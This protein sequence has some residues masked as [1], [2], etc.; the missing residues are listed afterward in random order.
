MIS[1]TFINPSLA[2]AVDDGENSL[3]T[4]Q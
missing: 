3:Q 2:S 1:E 4:E